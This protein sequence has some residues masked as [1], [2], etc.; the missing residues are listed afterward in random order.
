MRCYNAAMD[1]PVTRDQLCKKILSLGGSK[2]TLRIDW[3]IYI[4]LVGLGIMHYRGDSLTP[5]GQQIYF[6]LL[7]GEECPEVR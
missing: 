1:K 3:I 4:K 6:K 5:Y 2:C 7:R